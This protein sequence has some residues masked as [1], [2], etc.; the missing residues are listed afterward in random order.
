MDMEEARQLAA[1]LVLS[2]NGISYTNTTDMQAITTF[3]LNIFVRGYKA[4]FKEAGGRPPPGSIE[5]TKEGDL[6]VTMVY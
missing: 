3:T 4:G 5:V 1:Q 2:R 6:T